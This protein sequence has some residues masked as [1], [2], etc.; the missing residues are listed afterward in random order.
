VVVGVGVDPDSLTPFAHA[1][2]LFRAGLSVSEVKIQL[3]ARG[4][5]VGD[6]DVV[7]R[8]ARK[9]NAESA[10][11]ESEW[12]TAAES[13]ANEA[14]SD[15][16]ASPKKESK[17]ID[18][19]QTPCARCGTYVGE[20]SQLI[21]EKRYC[22]NC[23]ERRDVN[24]AKYYR[25]EYWGKRDSWAWFF[26][27]TGA[28]TVGAGALTLLN[29]GSLLGLVVLLSGFPGILFWS[30]WPPARLLL[31]VSTIFFMIAGFIAGGRSGLLS[32]IFAL[33]AIFSPRNKLFFRIEPTEAE[34]AAG[35][36]AA[37]SNHAALWSRGLA[38]VSVLTVVL[39]I[40]IREFAWLTG[41]LAGG[42]LVLGVIGL[43]NVKPKSVPPIDG[44][45]AAV[46]GTVLGILTIFGT[47]IFWFWPRL[48]RLF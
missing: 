18:I 27:V 32:V 37:N 13:K 15:S 30:G 39:W 14:V 22:A 8:A 35:F 16:A 47:A 46:V 43:S 1:V 36:H 21:L 20:S 38:L 5:D 10:P 17:L 12:S 25:D 4:L 3:L 44:K 19:S 28:L 48:E 34:L 11:V 29:T 7:L 33:W 41:F 6:V 2:E 26:G 9:R 24:F 42:A 40:V 31:V 45:T 23:A